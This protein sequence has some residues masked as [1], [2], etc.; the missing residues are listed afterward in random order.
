MDHTVKIKDKV[1]ERLLDASQIE[2]QIERVACELDAAYANVSQ[3]VVMVVTLS[4][5]MAFAWELS[6][7]ISFPVE[8]VFIKCSSYGSEMQSCGEVALSVVGRCELEGRDVLVIED[9]VDSGNTWVSLHN[10]FM[11]LLPRT[12]RIATLSIK[13]EVYDKALQID[14]VALELENRFVVGY[15]LDYDGG[16]RNLNGIYEFKG[17]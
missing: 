17:V 3:P 14:F 16:G 2:K 15:G 9:I 5:A 1:F 8:W 10:H 4:G 13:R 12:L 11:T 7:R 6:K